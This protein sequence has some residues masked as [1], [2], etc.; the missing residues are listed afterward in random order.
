MFTNRQKTYLFFKR[1][2]DIFGS[3]LGI[4]ILSP[5]LLLLTIISKCTSKGPVL[6]RQKR[7]GMSQKPFTLYKFRSMRVDAKQVPPDD[8][9][10]EEQEAMVTKWGHFIRK[11]SLDEIPQLFNIFA[12]H[13]SFVGPRPSQDAK[14]EGAL[15]KERNSYVPSAYCVRPG[16]SGYSQVYL[17]RN[18]DYKEKARFDSLYVQRFGFVMDIKIFL[19]S[20]LCI[21][22]YDR[23]R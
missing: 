5:L 4:V 6:F 21:F 17:H 13:M 14:H 9:T 1:A 16:L 19:K 2:I 20:F 3:T 22:G 10:P 8:M 18:H 12:G 7:L 23:G 15:V 11:T